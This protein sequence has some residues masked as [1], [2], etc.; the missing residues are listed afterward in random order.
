[1]AVL[2]SAVAQVHAAD[3]QKEFNAQL[4][5]ALL[6][7]A[8]LARVKELIEVRRADITAV[9]ELSPFKTTPI[10]LAVRSSTKDSSV[11][12]Y[13]IGCGADVNG[14]DYDGHI[15]LHD[16]CR[17]NFLDAVKIL[18]ECGVN[19]QEK[20]KRGQT[21]LDI[22]RESGHHNVV[23]F[24]EEYESASDIKEPEGN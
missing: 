17:Y 4:Y 5:T 10:H 1:M 21:P 22:A 11:L 18:L 15:P 19:T 6:Q 24:L 12:V 3:Q 9:V 16:A 13:L 23:Q 2:L 20:N 7:R 14:K 8:S